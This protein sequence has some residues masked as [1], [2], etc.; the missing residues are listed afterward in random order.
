MKK[1]NGG[2]T[3]IALI[4][5]IVV[6]LILA[7]VSLNFIAGE[8]GILRRAEKGVSRTD[9]ETAR[10]KLNL[11][12]Q[13]LLI[14][15]KT[16][17]EYSEIYLKNELEDQ[18][19]TFIEENIV[20]VDGYQFMIDKENLKVIE[21][22][23]KG[24][25]NSEIKITTTQQITDNKGKCILSITIEYAGTIQSVTMAGEKIE[26]QEDKYVAEITQNGSYTILVRDDNNGY[27]IEKVEISG[28]RGYVSE[29]WKV[30]D[31]IQFKDGVESG[32]SYE[33]KTVKLKA[34]L[35]LENVT[36][37]PIGYYISEEDKVTFKGTFDGENHTI[38]NLRME[39]AS[40]AA[41]H[42][43]GGF[44]GCIEEGTV[45]NLNLENVSDRKSVV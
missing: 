35:N 4:V 34:N 37:E 25:E 15:K 3:L 30:E 13:T 41:S 43:G 36:W 19:F 21:S 7:G 42:Y 23:G 27:R 1:R 6:L 31:L 38:S 11:E 26:K 17:P 14:D 40:K 29:I 16:N 28:L 32:L 33:G 18:G 24:K 39:V 44:F 2:I 9:E 12:L 20:M 5:T 8:Q 10:E 22:I 45:K